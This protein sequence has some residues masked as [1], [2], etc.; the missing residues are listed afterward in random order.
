MVLIFG[1][2][3]SLSSLAVILHLRLAPTRILLKL[4][5]GLLFI[6]LMA[7]E[8]LPGYALE[9]QQMKGPKNGLAKTERAEP[10]DVPSSSFQ[11]AL[12]VSA[13]FF[14]EWVSPIDGPRCNFSPTCSQYGY[15]AVH[16]YGPFLGIAM[17]ADRLMRCS[18]W[19]ETEPYYHRLPNGALHDPV[20]MNL[21][22]QP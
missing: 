10:D 1:S 16:N 17:T 12:L 14:Q 8:T 15:E 13:R 20:A 9:T 11:I 22:A 7:C 21:F 3:F 4:L 19:T 5:T 6:W 2:A 18:Y